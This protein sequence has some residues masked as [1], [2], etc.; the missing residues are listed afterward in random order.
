ME[1]GDTTVVDYIGVNEGGGV[2]KGYVESILGLV[3]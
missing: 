2:G 1:G 3:V